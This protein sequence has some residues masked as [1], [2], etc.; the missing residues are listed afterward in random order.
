MPTLPFTE[1]AIRVYLDNAIV[2]WRMQRTFASDLLKSGTDEAR[3]GFL[4]LQSNH[5]IDAYQ[6]V[7]SSIFGAILL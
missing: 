1:D 5:Y 6:S 3:A 2:Y 7:R 4:Y